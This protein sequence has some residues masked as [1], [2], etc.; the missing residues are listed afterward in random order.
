MKQSY[1]I[2]AIDCNID[3]TN[4]Y[5]NCYFRIYQKSDRRV[6]KSKARTTS[7]SSGISSKSIISLP[8]SLGMSAKTSGVSSNVGGFSAIVLVPHRLILLV[9]N[10]AY[11][12]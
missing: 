8:T 7:S 1:D 6:A 5:I 2:V 12:Q 4:R 11:Q 3:D 10:F 9:Y